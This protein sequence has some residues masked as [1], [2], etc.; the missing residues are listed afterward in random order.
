[1]VALLLDGREYFFEGRVEGE[2]LRQK[3]GNKGFGYDPLFRP[4]GYEL[5]F[6]QLEPEQ[7][8]RISHRAEAVQKMAR[9]LETYKRNLQK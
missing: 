8:N 4:E 9:F 6:A 5:S 7:K 1:V 3:A 2:I